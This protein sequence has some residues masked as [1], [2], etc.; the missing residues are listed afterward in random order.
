MAAKDSGA[1]TG[2]G[3]QAAHGTP[4]GRPAR[5]ANQ[6]AQR[7]GLPRAAGAPVGRHDAPEER[8]A[9]V[10]AQHTRNCACGGT[11]P[12]CAAAA[13]ATGGQRLARGDQQRFENRYGSNLDNI[14]LHTGP[15]AAA[16]TREVGASAFAFD[17][18]IVLGPSVRPGTQRGDRVLAHEL[19]HIALGDSHGAIRRAPPENE[20][21]QARALR[22]DAQAEKRDPAAGAT[23]ADLLDENRISIATLSDSADHTRRVLARVIGR[24]GL[25][26][27]GV[28]VGRMEGEAASDLGT[29]DTRTVSGI[30]RAQYDL[31]KEDW[32]RF[33]LMVRTLA[34][35]RLEHN[36][37]SLEQWAGYVRG[38]PDTRVRADMVA[39]DHLNFLDRA[40]ER[41]YVGPINMLE[42]AEVWATT[43]SPGEREFAAAVN[44]GEVHG[45][46]QHCHSVKA[47][48]DYDRSFSPFAEERVPLHLRA[49]QIAVED[50]M[51]GGWVPPEIMG[52]TLTG[53]TA[54]GQMRDTFQGPGV[55]SIMDSIDMTRP[56]FR[57]LQQ[58]VTGREAHERPVANDM[59]DLI[60]QLMIANVIVEDTIGSGADGEQI[61]GRILGAISSRQEQMRDLK[62][63]VNESD[64]DFFL[65][66]E[67]VQALI[68]GVDAD[69]RIMMRTSQA[70]KAQEKQDR[71]ILEAILGI[72]ALLL[73]VTPLAPLGVGIGVGLAVSQLEQGIT[74]L[75]EGTDIMRGTGAGVFSE[76]QEQAAGSMIAGGL[77]N[78]AMSVVDLGL[79]GV[80]AVHSIRAAGAARAADAPTTSLAPRGAGGSSEALRPDMIW[81][82]PQ[83]DDATGTMRFT[84]QRLT[85]DGAGESIEVMVDMQNRVATARVQTPQGPVTVRFGR[86]GSVIVDPP[87]GAAASTPNT[88]GSYPILTA[89]SGS[90][91]LPGPLRLPPGDPP[92][93]AL[94]PGETS[95]P[96][97]PRS[98]FDFSDVSGF[99]EGAT[100]RQFVVSPE[101]VATPEFAGPRWLV[102]PEGVVVPDLP[103]V[104]SD[105]PIYMG[106]LAPGQVPRIDLGQRQIAVGPLP[107]GMPS[108]HEVFLNPRPGVTTQTVNQMRRAPSGAAR[109]GQVRGAQLED[110]VTEAAGPLAQRGGSG[111]RTPVTGQ[112][113]FPDVR[114]PMFGNTLSY[115]AKNYLRWISP[116]GGG[117]AA[118]REV[119]LSSSLS[120]QV[121]NDAFLMNFGT[122]NYRPVWVFGNAPPSAELAN[123]LRQAGIPYMMFGDRLVP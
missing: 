110:F 75:M 109:P 122:T 69:V 25:D 42:Q 61:R 106:D 65:L 84:A 6:T 50:V 80:G 55:T 112:M 68:G 62:A 79:T 26:E 96:A 66:Q 86:N 63:D 105:I 4:K 102:T 60:R 97:L 93:L 81:S 89:G 43:A 2:R 49:R 83:V 101:G 87:A 120:Q 77:A 12:A 3:G 59:G 118:L 88:T 33:S 51:N 54:T 21:E 9:E 22:T 94:P 95:A 15:A 53:E 34:A 30:A 29:A 31:L 91:D 123:A 39:S 76:A 71:A 70:T 73:L 92:R 57:A 103:P 58:Q 44:R 19:A 10:V 117:T 27:T 116:T 115:E 99:G 64:Y 16:A 23:T 47:I 48:P 119:P 28:L 7:L 67:M 108:W 37:Q 56:Q 78:I 5:L 113:R 107:E 72:G 82:R 46:C 38:M 20:S 8:R 35:M 18:S 36:I 14:R 52:Q 24:R 85:A 32:D 11:C 111:L 121:T 100:G 40:M 1:K 114:Q 74:G 13:A 98:E 45:G 104:R 17:S 90:P 41:P